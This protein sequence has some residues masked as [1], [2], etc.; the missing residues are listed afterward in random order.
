MEDKDKREK[1]K[2][3]KEGVW[4]T[5][6]LRKEIQDRTSKCAEELAQEGVRVAEETEE[7]EN[8]AKRVDI[9]DEEDGAAR[10]GESHRSEGEEKKK[11]TDWM[12]LLEVA[13]V[14]D[15]GATEENRGKEP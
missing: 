1:V 3:E 2:R 5:A 9:R 12:E 7:R 13:R 14:K 15:T 4:V 6:K 11:K 8:A 10:D